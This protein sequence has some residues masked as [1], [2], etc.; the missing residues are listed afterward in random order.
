MDVVAQP[1]PPPYPYIY[2]LRVYTLVYGVRLLFMDAKTQKG[3]KTP[4]T[5][6]PPPKHKVLLLGVL[7]SV[8]PTTP[9]PPKTT[10]F[11]VFPLTGIKI[12]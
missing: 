8:G 5:P 3:Q 11:G 12:I 10:I 2:N 7:E 9:L 6:P 1:K 4:Q